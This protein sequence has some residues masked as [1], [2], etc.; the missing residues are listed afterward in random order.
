MVLLY[1][2]KK[3]PIKVALVINVFLTRLVCVSF[4]FLFCFENYCCANGSL[5]LKYVFRNAH[6]F[7]PAL[8]L[9]DHI[10]ILIRNL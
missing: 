4:I 10:L 2:N 8:Y 7:L 3:V 6:S 5:I 1:N 9:Y